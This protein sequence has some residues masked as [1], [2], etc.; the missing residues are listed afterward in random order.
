MVPLNITTF[1]APRQ[2]IPAQMLIL[3]GCLGSFCIEQVVISY[4]M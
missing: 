4:G 1:V 3:G 2:D